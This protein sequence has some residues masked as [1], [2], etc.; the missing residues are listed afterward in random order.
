MNWYE[1]LYPGFVSAL[2]G[3]GLGAAFGY[4][5]GAAVV[6]VPGWSAWSRFFL[7]WGPP[8]AVVPGG[9]LIAHLYLRTHLGGWLVERGAYDRALEYTEERLDPG[10]MRSRRETLYHRI[11]RARARIGRREYAAA[12]ETLLEGYSV[13]ETG[14]EA[15]AVR[16]WQLEVELRRERGR[17]VEEAYGEGIESE[18]SPR[19]RAALEAGRAE[20]A[21]LEGS[22]EAYHTHLDRGRSADPGAV[23]IDLAEGFGAVRFGGDD[24]A[25]ERGLQRLEKCRDEAVREVPGRAAEIDAVRAQLLARLGRREEARERLGEAEREVGDDRAVRRVEHVSELFD[26]KE[27]S[28]VQ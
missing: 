5:V 10:L 8:L 20:W 25:Y 13:P 24:E 14:R 27:R 22:P 28:D 21:V 17:G 4:F 26:E 11:Y 1:R 9:L 12:V 6:F 3:V 7:A 15:E 19:M 16:R 2:G 23:R 18:P